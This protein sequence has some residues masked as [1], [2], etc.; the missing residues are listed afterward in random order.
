MINLVQRVV[1]NRRCVHCGRVFPF[2]PQM[3]FC[4]VCKRKF[5]D[6][7]IRTKKELIKT[8]SLKEFEPDF[9]F[10]ASFEN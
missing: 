4:P 1:L 8:H 6:V 5:I 7:V 9:K 3:I 10:V 2:N